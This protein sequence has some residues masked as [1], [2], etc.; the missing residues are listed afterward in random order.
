MMG[1]LMDKAFA[2]IQI[3]KVPL[4]SLFRYAKVNETLKKCKECPRYN[5][6]WSCPP[7]TPSILTYGGRFEHATLFVFKIAYPRELCVSGTPREQLLKEREK[8]YD[9]RR[10][11][12]QITLLDAEQKSPGSL[13]VS[14]CLICDRCARMDGEPCRHPDQMRYSMTTLGLDFQKMLDDIF[15]IRLDWSCDGL[16]PYDYCVAALLEPSTAMA[17]RKRK[18]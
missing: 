13:S 14:T 2:D 12:I 8:Y 4:R 17:A 15:D 16:T 10:R 3:K 5:N 6:S 1:D 9:D 11:K 18:A 7:Q